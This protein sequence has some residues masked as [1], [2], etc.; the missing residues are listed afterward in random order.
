ML[1]LLKRLEEADYI[2]VLI[3]AVVVDQVGC[4][5]WAVNL[6]TFHCFLVAYAAFLKHGA[7]MA[8]S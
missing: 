7:A 2:S 8:I 5:V 1:E 4:S 6:V 3:Y